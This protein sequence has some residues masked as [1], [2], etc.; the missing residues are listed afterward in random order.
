MIQLS[1]MAAMRRVMRRHQDV[2]PPGR[3][4]IPMW[5]LLGG[6]L[7]W[8]VRQLTARPAVLAGL[9][10]GFAATLAVLGAAAPGPILEPPW[11]VVVAL[12]AGW[13][14]AGAT[15]QVQELLG[16]E[17][18]S[19]PAGDRRR[20]VLGAGIV[21]GGLTAVV[22]VVWLVVWLLTGLG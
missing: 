16:D 6:E 17:P 1:L 9:L 5:R 13:L 7:L 12:G 4:R 2:P 19:A 10:A 22:L 11:R 20:P 14:V 3:G 21:S 8:A 15:G 18:R